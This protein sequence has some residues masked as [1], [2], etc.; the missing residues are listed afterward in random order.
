ME[1]TTPVFDIYFTKSS[2]PS[3]SGEIVI[4]TIASSYPSVISLYLSTPGSKI[5]F[6]FCAPIASLL[7][8]GP[9]K[10]APKTFAP[11]V[12][13]F[14][15]NCITFNAFLVSETDAVIVVGVND[16]VPCFT[17]VSAI[18]FIDSTV[19]SIVSQFPAPCI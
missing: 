4:E 10:C 17:I 16:V 9:S 15:H 12:P 5:Y 11:L 6:P 7:I 8:N 1:H 13:V 14:L 2:A 3:T 18:V 19:P